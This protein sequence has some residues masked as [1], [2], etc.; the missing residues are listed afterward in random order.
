MRAGGVTLGTRA[1]AGGSEGGAQ[2]AVAA[3]VT[4][5]WGGGRGEVEENRRRSKQ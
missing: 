1:A 2:A 5:G 3:G 4:R